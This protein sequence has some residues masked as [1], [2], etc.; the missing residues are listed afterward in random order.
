MELEVNDCVEKENPQEMDE[1][2][3]RK[4]VKKLNQMYV[5]TI[6]DIEFYIYWR[7]S[8]SDDEM[9]KE[10]LRHII[11]DSVNEILH[12]VDK[13]SYILDE[14]VQKEKYDQV[15]KFDYEI[16]AAWY[17]I[18]EEIERRMVKKQQESRLYAEKV[19]EVDD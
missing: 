11:D 16:M 8:G 14:N 13:V 1:D 3:F 6:D 7:I 19:V 2:V 9:G 4:H 10:L 12:E 5:H 18:E 15:K 17:N